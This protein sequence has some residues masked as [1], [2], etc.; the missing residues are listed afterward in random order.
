MEIRTARVTGPKAVERVYGDEGDVGSEG[1]VALTC[2][3][4]EC[5]ADSIRGPEK[6]RYVCL[7]CDQVFVE[8]PCEEIDSSLS[9]WVG[10]QRMKV[11][12]LPAC[13]GN[14]DAQCGICLE[15]CSRRKHCVNDSPPSYGSATNWVSRDLTTEDPV[16]CP[17]CGTLDRGRFCSNCGNPLHQAAEKPFAVAAIRDGIVKN[18]PKYLK[19][20]GMVFS[21]PRK[22][23]GGA[24]SQQA[25]AF[26]HYERTLPPSEFLTHNLTVTG[27]LSLLLNYLIGAPATNILVLVFS[28]VTDLL[29]T[30]GW[31]F[32]PAG[33]LVFFIRRHDKIHTDRFRRVVMTSEPRTSV[34]TVM[35]VVAYLSSLEVLSLPMFVI[36][37][38]SVGQSQHSSQPDYFWPFFVLALASKLLSQFWLAPLALSYSCQI[39]KNAALYAVTNLNMIPMVL[40]S[41][42]RGCARLAQM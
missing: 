41:I 29:L 23:F 34:S 18:W 37:F 28:S 26:H 36:A 31:M 7:C 22:L 33:L 19:T 25:N 38:E 9:T 39:S 1:G 14:Y 32:V 4:P 13:F 15:G 24:F 30:L 3:N 8:Q 2:K 11:S 17:T 10:W 42:L 27:L 16:K 35:R 40:G 6:G 20:L 12:D 5:G 21:N